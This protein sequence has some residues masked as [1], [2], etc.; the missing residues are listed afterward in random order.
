MFTVDCFGMVHKTRGN[1][2]C[3]SIMTD[4]VHRVAT[5]LLDMR[6]VV[7]ARL[8]LIRD[9]G[10]ELQLDSSLLPRGQAD[11]NIRRVIDRRSVRQLIAQCSFRFT[12]AAP[13]PQLESG[14][15]A[16]AAEGSPLSGATV[17]C[18]HQMIAKETLR[19]FHLRYSR[20]VSAVPKTCQK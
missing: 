19:L 3:Q 11:E 20:L 2:G 18:R 7:G 6:C 17:Q 12:F 8:K 10:K 4:T 5:L 16:R 1:R 14:R 15:P 9:G 13:V